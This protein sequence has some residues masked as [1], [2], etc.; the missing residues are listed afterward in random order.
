L[1]TDYKWAFFSWSLDFKPRGVAEV[2]R[3]SLSTRDQYGRLTAI[4]SVHL[5]LLSEGDEIINPPEN[6]EERCII[7]SP[8]VGKRVSGGVLELNGKNPPIQ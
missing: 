6:F 5:V 2:G 1:N 4:K 8:P 3:L 7:D